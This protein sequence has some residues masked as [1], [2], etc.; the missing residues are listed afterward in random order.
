MT[1]TIIASRP[2]I[3]RQLRSRRAHSGREL[4]REAEHGAGPRG[5]EAMHFGLHGPDGGAHAPPHVVRKAVQ[6]KSGGGS[7]R[8]LR[9]L[10]SDGERKGEEL[11]ACPC[12]PVKFTT[13]WTLVIYI[14]D[15]RPCVGCFCLS[16]FW[17]WSQL[18]FQDYLLTCS[19]RGESVVCDSVVLSLFS[20][21]P[22]GQ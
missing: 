7:T 11:F 1:K 22:F 12:T 18:F 9:G 13:C 14:Y 15:S 3:T 20:D 5:R 17:Q 16:Q 8:V 19:T 4:L 2:Y 10:E 6:F 21:V